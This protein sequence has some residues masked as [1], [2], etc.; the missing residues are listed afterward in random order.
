MS[1][2]DVAGDVLDVGVEGAG[3]DEL[4]GAD[5]LDSLTGW[6]AKIKVDVTMSKIFKVFIVKWHIVFITRLLFF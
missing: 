1:D 3:C 2:V 6:Q 4:K 5:E